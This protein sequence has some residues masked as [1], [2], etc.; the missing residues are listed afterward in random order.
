MGSVGN[1]DGIAFGPQR[2][3]RT[4][5]GWDPRNKLVEMGTATERGLASATE[6]RGALGAGEAK[7]EKI[8]SALGTARA[9]RRQSQTAVPKAQRVWTHGTAAGKGA[10]VSAPVPEGLH[11]QKREWEWLRGSAETLRNGSHRRPSPIVAR[12]KMR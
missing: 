6:L 1:A 12:M 11:W 8:P 5:P 2:G 4:P 3:S 9:R 7:M 10:R